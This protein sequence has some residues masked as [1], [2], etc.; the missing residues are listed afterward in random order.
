MDD[1][2]STPWAWH[3]QP[4]YPRHMVCQVVKMGMSLG[5]SPEAWQSLPGRTQ[6]DVVRLLK[7]FDL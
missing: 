3:K 6:D 5:M 7:E 1:A 2:M 4:G